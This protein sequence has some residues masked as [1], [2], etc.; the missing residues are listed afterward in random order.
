MLWFHISVRI[1]TT[2][3]H[4]VVTKYH[5]DKAAKST[6]KVFYWEINSV[7]IMHFQSVNCMQK[8]TYYLGQMIEHYD[9]L[10]IVLNTSHDHQASSI[11]HI[12]I[13]QHCN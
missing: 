2:R 5:K 11:H 4:L 1:L 7:S 12:F 13:R 9:G 6:C 3:I 10:Y 8:H